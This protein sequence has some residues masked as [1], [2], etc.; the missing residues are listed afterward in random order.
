M[1]IV[2]PR[3]QSPQYLHRH[4]VPIRI[5]VVQF[6]Y[7][8]RFSRFVWFCFSF[9][10]FL[11]YPRCE[12]GDFGGS[13]WLPDCLGR[14]APTILGKNHPLRKIKDRGK[15]TDGNIS[16]SVNILKYVLKYVYFLY[17]L[18]LFTS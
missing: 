10:L 13:F 17:K 14:A 2:S 9:F 7:F 5:V 3:I 4:L 12:R 18:I 16:V 6:Y 11:S 8:P 1:F 15:Y